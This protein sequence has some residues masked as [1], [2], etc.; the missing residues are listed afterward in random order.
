MEPYSDRIDPAAFCCQGFHRIFPYP[1]HIIG[2]SQMI[3]VEVNIRQCIDSLE[4]QPDG[5]AA[6]QFLA[7]RQGGLIFILPLHHG[8]SIVLTVSPVWILHCPVFQPGPV[9]SSRHFRFKTLSGLAASDFPAFRHFLYHH[10][11][12]H[13]YFFRITQLPPGTWSCFSP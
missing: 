3:S 4:F 2:N 8:Q 5:S 10:D 9:H 11:F 7:K 13:P 12:L 1:V 6:H